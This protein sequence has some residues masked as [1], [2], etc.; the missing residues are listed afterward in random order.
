M[1]MWM[2]LLLLAATPFWQEKPPAEWNDLQIAQFLND[3]P[4]GPRRERKR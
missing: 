1:T 2:L 4:V 3:S